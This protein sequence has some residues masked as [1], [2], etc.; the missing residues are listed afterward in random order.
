MNCFDEGYK[1]FYKNT[2]AY[3]SSI[4]SATWINDVEKEVDKL[5][6]DLNSFQGYK[7]DS[8][9][10]QGD[11]AEFFHA[12]TF[13]VKA[14]LNKSS[15]RAY[16]NRSHGFAS[17]DI[18]TNF[19]DNYGLKYYKD[20]INSAKAQAKSVFERYKEYQAKGGTESLNEFLK[21]RGYEDIDVLNDPIY[22]G[23]KRLIPKD[24]L[25]EAMEWLE[26]KIAKEAKSRP[27]QVKRYE[28]TLKLLRDRIKDNEGN[29]SIP[30]SREDAEYLAKLAKEGKID[31]EELGLTLNQL[32]TYE[33]IVR[34]AFAAGATSATITAVLKMAP[35]IVA[36]VNYLLDNGEIEYEQFE[37][38]GFAA[39]G[40]SAE[41]FLRGSI[42]AAITTSCKTGLLGV[43]AKNIDPSIIGMATVILMD[44]MKN[45]YY[46]A[47]GQMKQQELANELVKETYIA[48]VSLLMGNAIQLVLPVPVLG[49]MLGSFAGSVFGGLTYSKGH[50]LALSFCT[51]T[52]F[53][54][55]GLVDQDYTLPQDVLEQIG[56][57]TFEPKKT[58][59]KQ[60]VPRSITPKSMFQKQIHPK[61]IQIYVLRRGV[62]G[63]NT[64]GYI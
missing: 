11:I 2:G 55:F 53:T 62:I 9:K 39:I 27:E 48:S 13:N 8:S 5:C 41:G 36:A 64:I 29:E 54:M 57:K 1:F 58:E 56:V 23:Q 31:P 44:T 4:D 42:S 59:F 10:L 19:G 16:I 38:I 37:K 60:I 22:S 6:N 25:E 63:V 3:T 40:G 20:G 7:T 50:D 30:L 14:S 21:N 15:H 17:S 49:F 51:N 35:E 26:Q 52:G 18:S 33:Y 45:S 61:T 24:Q 46:V 47:I 28:E 34:Q 43:A 32:V 12:G